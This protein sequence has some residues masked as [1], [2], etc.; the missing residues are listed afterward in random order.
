MTMDISE[1]ARA[2]DEAL[3]RAKK[4][5]ETCD[6]NAVVGWCEYLFPKLKS[7]D[8]RIKEILIEH[9]KDQDTDF[10]IKKWYGFTTEDLINWLEKQ[11]EKKPVPKFSVGDYVVDT[12]YRGE[13]LYQIVGIDKECYIC[14]YRG[15]KEMGDRAVMHFAFDNPYLHHKQ[16]PAWSEE[17]EQ[18]LL[19]C[20]NALAKYQTTDKWDASIISQ[21]L[22]NRLKR[23]SQVTQA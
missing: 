11:D 1:K 21:W 20:K 22:E 18:Y 12:N 5:Q 9:I 10:G 13:P 2:Y 16:K 15:D 7:K 8:E 17:D 6:S 23:G 19:V 4:L 3:E 14:Q